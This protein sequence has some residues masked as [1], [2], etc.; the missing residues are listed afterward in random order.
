MKYRLSLIWFLFTVYIYAQKIEIMNPNGNEV[1]TYS[2]NQ[3]IYI[4]KISFRYLNVFFSKNNGKDWQLLLRDKV[5]GDYFSYSALAW[6]VPNVKSDS[7]LIKV[8]DSSDSLN[9]DVS[10]KIFSVASGAMKNE[11][12]FPLQ[13][14]NAWFFVYEGDL[15]NQPNP[16]ILTILKVTKDTLM[17]DGNRYAVIDRYDS[18]Y[19]NKWEKYKGNYQLLRVEGSKVYE[20]PNKLLFD[21]NWTELDIRPGG[22]FSFHSKYVPL[23]GYFNITY[24]LMTFTEEWRS[25]TDGIGFYELYILH[26]H[27]YQRT[28]RTLV[29][30][31]LN[32]KNYGNTITNI[33]N[34]LAE[35]PK[36]FNLLQNYPNPFNPKTVIKYQLPKSGFVRL[37][38]YDILGNEVSTLVD[39]FVY[40]GEYEVEFNARNVPSGVYFYTLSSGNYKQTKKLLLLK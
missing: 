14:G 38:V 18:T 16:K 29:G 11:F 37:K 9:Y 3:Y 23:F 2:T 24:Y 17:N 22:L 34:E 7:C 30:C 12:N 25:Y 6:Q 33:K 21:C 20:Y 5:A 28:S 8:V 36:E 31:L 32:G 15:Y 35:L 13:V 4:K 40:A 1:F 26:W 27:D 19:E 10:D 39:S